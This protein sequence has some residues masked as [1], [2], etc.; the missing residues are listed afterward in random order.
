MSD[1]LNQQRGTCPYCLERCRLNDKH[2]T[3]SHSVPRIV[4]K[5]GRG[6]YGRGLVALEY[7]KRPYTGHTY[8]QVLDALTEEEQ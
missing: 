1:W 5:D 7:R 8:L 2:R 3:L 4:F 6:C